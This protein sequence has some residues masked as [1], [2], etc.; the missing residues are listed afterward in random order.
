MRNPMTSWPHCVSSHS[1]IS[2]REKLLT[3]VGYEPDG[4]LFMESY[5][6]S[7]PVHILTTE[8][9]R[10][11]RNK[12]PVSTIGSERF[13]CMLTRDCE[14]EIAGVNMSRV[15]FVYDSSTVATSIQ[16]SPVAEFQQPSIQVMHSFPQN[17]DTTSQTMR[18]VPSVITQ[19]NNKVYETPAIKSRHIDPNSSPRRRPEG[20]PIKQRI[21]PGLSEATELE[22]T[23]SEA[24]NENPFIPTAPLETPMDVDMPGTPKNEIPSR[25]TTA[26]VADMGTMSPLDNPP[27][28]DLD[29][30][31]GATDSLPVAF[32][33]VAEKTK[34]EEEKKIKTPARQYGKK[35]AKPRKT[36]TETPAPR[37]DTEDSAAPLTAAQKKGTKRKATAVEVRINTEGTEGEEVGTSKK[38]RKGKAGTPIPSADEEEEELPVPKPTKTRGKGKKKAEPAPETEDEEPFSTAFEESPVVSTEEKPRKSGKKAPTKPAGSTTGDTQYTFP[39]S[40][41]EEQDGTPVKTPKA[42]GKAAAKTPT[43]K[44]TPATTRKKATPRARSS[45]TPVPA[46]SPPPTLRTTDHYDGPSPRI[47]FSSSNLIDDKS[48]QKFIRGQSGKILASPSEASCNFLVVGEL[49]RTP[50]FIIAVARGIRIVEEAWLK[51]SVSAGY[52]VDPD[53]YVP[54]DPEREAEWG[55]SL[56][57]ALKRGEKGETKVLKGLTVYLTPSLIA[58]LKALKSEEGLV[59]MLKAAGAEA[60]HKKAPRGEVEEDTLVLGKEDGEKDLVALEKGGWKVYG[61]GVIGLSVMRGALETGDEFLVKPGTAPSSEKEKKGKGGR[62]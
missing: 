16:R 45:T 4:S 8:H 44:K 60:V 1:T 24:E 31:Q 14:I 18:P 15:V 28:D 10:K 46:A 7:K 57:D 37:S 40:L 42:R 21:Q 29:L 19:D 56:E 53:P 43:T 50:K 26:P 62:R 33:A 35:G 12:L 49:K 58:H 25:H 32:K 30:D 6:A 11:I 22:F 55:C 51:D 47:S 13:Y 59:G 54:N 39:G 41:D 38:K 36:A 48:T 3:S 17:T 2:L 23:E 27:E 20:S 9:T 61:T 5:N 34:Y 52:F